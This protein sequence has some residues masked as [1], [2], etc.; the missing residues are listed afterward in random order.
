MSVQRAENSFV[1]GGTIAE[2]AKRV[3]DSLK[4]PWVDK[5][6]A[7]VAVFPFI[8]PVVHHFDTLGFNIPDM[9]YVLQTGLLAG[10]M[11]FRNPPR[12]VTANPLFWGLAFIATYWGFLAIGLEG[13]G[14]RVAPEWLLN[15]I[16]ALTLAGIFWARI[17]LGRNIGF[18]PAQRE[19]VTHGMY[20]YIRHPIYAVIFVSIAGAM[21]QRWSLRNALVLA[22]GVA[23]FAVKS[24][25]EEGLLK[26]DAKYAA[27]MKKVPYRFIPW[28]F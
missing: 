20:R 1:P 14:E 9:V 5:A 22:G 17:S 11:V 28:V 13:P 18:V 15:I 21:M 26:Q 2:L 7:A 12:R 3:G 16:T 27:Y 10:T 23:L 4:N 24:F 19:I 6:I 8:Y 25:V